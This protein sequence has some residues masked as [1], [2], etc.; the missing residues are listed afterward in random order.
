LNDAVKEGRQKMNAR[1]EFTRTLVRYG[2]SVTLDMLVR[3]SSKDCIAQK[4]LMKL[5]GSSAAW[6]F[7]RKIPTYKVSQRLW[8][9]WT[10]SPN[11]LKEST[12]DASA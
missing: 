11:F 9:Y 8:D 2:Y 10:A 4:L 1:D 7:L 12:G 6:D 3:A 5:P